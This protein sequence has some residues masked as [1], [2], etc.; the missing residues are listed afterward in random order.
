M[1]HVEDET[2]GTIPDGISID[3]FANDS[4]IQSS[5]VLFDIPRDET[6]ME[7]QHDD[8]SE[9]PNSNQFI[10][11]NFSFSITSFPSKSA[12]EEY[13]CRICQ[14]EN[15]S[16]ENIS[17]C[18]CRGTMGRI[19]RSCLEQWLATS[20]SEKCEVC[21]FKF[22]VTRRPKYNIFQALIVWLT[23][24]ESRRERL[25]MISDSIGFLTA[26]PLI[27]L[28]N[29]QSITLLEI[30]HLDVIDTT[31]FYIPIFLPNLVFNEIMQATGQLTT[32]FIMGAVSFLDVFYFT[33]LFL[34]MHRHF[35]EW[36]KWY[37]TQCEVHL[38]LPEN[39]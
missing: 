34:R 10:L 20:D 30:F 1:S 27:L 8:I 23:I 29:H 35:L 24:E 39:K 5:K 25:L 6:S 37:R 16:E 13:F 28:A 4:P 7:S 11:E 36:Y 26:F 38:I 19:H 32:F 17:P 18:S 21:G 12:A 3:S 31:D 2:K 9:E 15:V 22:T 14:E 33:W